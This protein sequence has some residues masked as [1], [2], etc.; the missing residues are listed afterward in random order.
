MPSEKLEV[1]LHSRHYS[2]K[3]DGYRF[4]KHE[5]GIS[6]VAK[7]FK[8]LKIVH[9][10]TKYNLKPEIVHALLNIEREI[11]QVKFDK[12]VNT[13]QSIVMDFLCH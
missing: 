4:E 12:Q 13:R 1:Y 8:L 2:D 11:E 3:C 10:H 7:L 5:Y 6:I 9:C